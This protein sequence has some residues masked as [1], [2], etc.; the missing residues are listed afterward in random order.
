[1][2]DKLR[3]DYLNTE[4]IQEDEIDI[5]EI[6]RIIRSYRKFIA[7]IFTVVL[8]I[9]IYVTLTSQPVYQATTVVM[10]KESGS[11]AGSFVFDFGMTGSK[12]RLQNETEVLKS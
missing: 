5:N 10:I 6:W 11:D 8:A 2:D 7:I 9:T 4:P 12:Q 3:S 1:M